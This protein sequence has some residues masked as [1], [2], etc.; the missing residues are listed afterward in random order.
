MSDPTRSPRVLFIEPYYGGSHASFVDTLTSRI[1]ADWTVLSL[2]GRHWKWRAQGSA[3]WFAQE[4]ADTLSAGY[5]LVLASSYVSMTDLVSLC[6]AIKDV[7]RYLYFHENQFAYP[8]RA[9]HARD[10]DW[11]Y[12]FRQLVSA[13]A[14]DRLLF[15]S[16][17]NLDSFL[18]GGAQL[19]KRMPDAVPRDWLEK[20]K[21]RSTVL[22]VPL[23]LPKV[24]LERLEL[25]KTDRRKGPIVL[26]NHRWEFDKAPEVFFGALR[27]LKERGVAFR[28][29][30]C[31][32]RFR[33]SPEV[34]EQSRSWLEDRIVH[35]G[36]CETRDEYESL[37]RR[38]HIAV[39]TA[40]HEFFGIAM[41]EAT[42]FGAFPLVPDALAYP[43]HFGTE[44]R[45]GNVEGL[46]NTMEKLCRGWVD[47]AVEL[48]TDRQALTAPY[49]DPLITRYQALVDGVLD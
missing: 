22:P 12:G 18:A 23:T 3:V 45:Y 4:H 19:L 10:R 42:H 15:N 28:V 37:L 27:T 9:S 41:L 14:S 26:W 11:S 8:V 30:V 40:I 44:Y 29:A 16:Q 49:G 43:E 13:L 1:T 35:W 17:W 36:F 24:S 46:V 32:E 39:S 6:P 2:P 31:G 21:S 38:S 25:E 33:S 47:G 7:P 5:D 34:F 48:R 20:L